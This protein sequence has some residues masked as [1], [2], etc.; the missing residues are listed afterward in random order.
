M[1]F[2]ALIFVSSKLPGFLGKMRSGRGTEGL[3]SGSVDLEKSRERARQT[4]DDVELV[5][6]KHDIAA[7]KGLGSR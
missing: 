1:I 3:R 2:P 5:Q 4:S 7:S 6:M